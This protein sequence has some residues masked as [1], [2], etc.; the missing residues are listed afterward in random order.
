M[1]KNKKRKSPT[2]EHQLCADIRAGSSRYFIASHGS[3]RTA[4]WTEDEAIRA[5][6]EICNRKVRYALIVSFKTRNTELDIY[7]PIRTVIDVPISVETM[8]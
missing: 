1:A 6:T 5:S 3:P 4:E 2:Q 8:I 7:T